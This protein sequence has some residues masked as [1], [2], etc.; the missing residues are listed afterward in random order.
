MPTPALK[1]P[2]SPRPHADLAKAVRVQLVRAGLGEA[3]VDDVGGCTLAEARDRIA[4]ERDPATTGPL[5]PP[6]HQEVPSCA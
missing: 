1:V 6:A 2:G 4:A 3:S 5:T